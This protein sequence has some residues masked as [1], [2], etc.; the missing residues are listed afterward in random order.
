ML[1]L[2]QNVTIHVLVPFAI[3]ETIIWHFFNCLWPLVVDISGAFIFH[4]PDDWIDPHNECNECSN[5]VEINKC[6]SRAHMVKSSS[7]CVF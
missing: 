1:D 4:I 7:S 5:S 2:L 6:Y 3:R